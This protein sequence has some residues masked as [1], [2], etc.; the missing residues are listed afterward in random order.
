MALAGDATMV[1]RSNIVDV[2]QEGTMMLGTMRLT[3]AGVTSPEAVAALFRTAVE[4]GITTIDLADIY[5]GY[6]TERIVGDAFRYR[7]ELM[8]EFH[9][10]SKC[11]IVAPVGRHASARVKHYDTGRH[12]IETSVEASL[13]ALGA[14]HL[15][16]LLM[17][18]PD[19]LMDAEATGAVL[20]DLVDDGRV[21][22]VG[23]SNFRPWDWSLLQ[24]AM[25]RP[26]VANQIELSLSHLDPFSNGDVAFHQQHG[27]A[28][29]AW[30]PLG[31]GRVM[32]D[33]DTLGQRLDVLA[34]SN[35]VDRSAMAVAFLLHHPASIVPVL[36][37][38]SPER[39]RAVAQATTVKLDTEDWFW[40]YEAG[41]GSEVP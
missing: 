36:G 29:M 6:T 9:L 1:A 17:H 40:L 19:P 12:H 35:G 7:P 23:V 41:L 22:A 8:D 18:R 15:D 21:G 31:G 34:E 30:S 20:D 37:T 39:L 33:A 2:L 14:D 26:L 27:H 32:N 16:L 5:G 13:D 11:G 3:D 10:V 38:A 28:M 24:S 25:D 4:E